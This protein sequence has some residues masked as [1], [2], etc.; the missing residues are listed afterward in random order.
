MPSA[1]LKLILS[2]L[3]IKNVS[4]HIFLS[5]DS[6][7]ISLILIDIILDNTIE[8]RDTYGGDLPTA[9]FDMVKA[10]P[11]NEITICY[12]INIGKIIFCI[13]FKGELSNLNTF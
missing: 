4:K 6:D 2:C 1:L 9:V 12:D 8:L 11:S 5:F 10:Y 13:V 3:K 7:F